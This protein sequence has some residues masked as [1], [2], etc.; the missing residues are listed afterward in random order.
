M[1]LSTKVVFPLF[2]LAGSTGLISGAGFADAPAATAQTAPTQPS[3]ATTAAVQST[4][5]P[6]Q[7]SIAATTANAPVDPAA[8][9]IIHQ[10][11]VTYQGLKAFT[12]TATSGRGTATIA[13]ERPGKFHY[14]ATIKGSKGKIYHLAA[15]S[16]GKIY[17]RVAPFDQR[18]YFTSKTNTGAVADAWNSAGLYMFQA[19][20]SPTG[21]PG[22]LTTLDGPVKVK[23]GPMITAL[24]LEAPSAA[25]GVPIDVVDG[26]FVETF[27]SQTYRFHE[28]FS[29]GHDDHLIRKFT[30]DITTKQ[31]GKPSPSPAASFSET[32]TNVKALDALPSDAL[33]FTPP[34]GVTLG[35]AK[36]LADLEAD[37][38]A[39]HDRRLV[40]GAEPF[41]FKAADLTGNPI[42]LDR[43][44]GH[45]LLIDFWATWCGPCCEELPNVVATYKK[46]HNRGLDIVGISLDEKKSDLTTFIKQ[47][48]I[49][50][51]IVF[52]GNGW[53]NRVATLYKVHA[54]PFALLVGKDGRIAAVDVRG[55]S[56]TSAVKHALA[57][58]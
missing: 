44:R 53:D 27:G 30:E 58:E 25:D 14:E 9:T 36:L 33:V 12:E 22:N 21:I 7:P 4:P 47:K 5:A 50:Y 34:T 38:Q 40:V 32:Y 35:T 2:L 13:W 42:S 29:I 26:V 17:T 39:M 37:E 8:K 55:P 15:V 19:A 20:A 3:N 18:H 49:P 43:Y 57:V 11:F 45:V 16:D 24:T 54:I 51:P 52:D 41:A 46:F 1:K 6:V 31:T 28:V 48:H 10:C 23:G 56:L